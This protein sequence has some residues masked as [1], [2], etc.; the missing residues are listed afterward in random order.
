MP[1]TYSA[2]IG[3]GEVE[4]RLGLRALADR[5]HAAGDDL[6][7]G[8]ARRARLARARGERVAPDQVG[9]L[10]VE[11]DRQPAVGDL[12]GL[13]DVLGAERRDVDRDGVALGVG[14]DLQR[15]AEAGARAVLRAAGA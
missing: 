11:E 15:L 14:E 5:H 2:N 10:G 6:A 13:L 1:P 12:G 7:A 9:P 8:R 3:P 4:Q